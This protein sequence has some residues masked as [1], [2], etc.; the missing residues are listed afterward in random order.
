MKKSEFTVPQD[1]SLFV[2]KYK[3]QKA[4]YSIREDILHDFNVFAEASSLNK[5]GVIEKLIENFL[6][7]SG[8]RKKA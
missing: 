2:V 3:K 7:S 1:E 5:S 6:I 4:N 8:V